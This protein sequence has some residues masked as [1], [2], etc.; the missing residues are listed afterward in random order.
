METLRRV[1]VEALGKAPLEAPLSLETEPL[2]DPVPPGEVL[3]RV[4]AAHVNWVDVLMTSGQYQHVPEPPYT[5]GIEFA[6]EVVAC[7]E[8]VSSVRVGEAVIADGLHTGPR[9]LGAHRRWGGFATHALAPAHALIPK[10]APLSFE[11]AA[12]LLGSAETAYHALIARARVRAGEVVLVLGATGSTGLATVALAKLLG[13]RVIAVGR[14]AAKLEVARRHGAEHGVVVGEG[15]PPLREQ[16]KALT[17][18]RGADV[19]YDPIGGEA[20]VQAL[21]AAAFGARYLVVGWAATPLVGRGDRDPNVL[22]TNLILMKGIDVLGSP[23]AIAAHRD[24]AVRAERLPR[25]LAWAED[26][27]LRPEISARFPLE[28]AAEAMRAKWTGGHAGNVIITPAGAPA[29]A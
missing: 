5:P 16:V 27:Q 9:S 19:V 1:V 13:A 24:P 12:C 7:G 6:G 25:I 3:L 14:S 17:E 28:R 22:P 11:E 4:R 15:H 10:P 23:A 2:P 18:G 21:R 20:S 26:G 29:G 8:G